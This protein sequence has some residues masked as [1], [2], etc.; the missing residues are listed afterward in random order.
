MGIVFPITVFID[1]QLERKVKANQHYLVSSVAYFTLGF[2]LGIV[3]SSL[4]EERLAFSKAS[5]SLIASI[6][7]GLQL[8]YN[9][10]FF[11]KRQFKGGTTH[12]S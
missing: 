10:Y 3:A 1:P 8:H 11:L 4:T 9:L 6:G 12:V 2:I 5:L 7:A